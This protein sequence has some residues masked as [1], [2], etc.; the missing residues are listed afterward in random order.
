MQVVYGGYKTGIFGL[1]FLFNLTLSE[2]F[3]PTT[4]MFLGL[5][6]GQ[7]DEY[8]RHRYD[9]PGKEELV[10]SPVYNYN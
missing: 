7:L 8:Y 2:L 1:F 9:H 5:A 4:W 6:Y 10:D 3:L